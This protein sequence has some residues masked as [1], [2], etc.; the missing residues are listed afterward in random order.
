MSNTQFGLSLRAWQEKTTAQL[1]ALA[2]VATQDLAERVIDDTPVDT[3]NLVGN[4]QPSL[5]APNLEVTDG[6]LGNGYAQSALVATIQQF[7][8]GEVFYY[9]NN[10]AYARRIEFGFVGPDS[11]GRVYN[12]A[13]RYMVTKAVAAWDSIVDGAAVKLGMTK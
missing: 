5:S 3:G 7:K 6:A 8:A 13:G 9:T 1:Q 11:L 10:A 4:W 2:R 12:Q